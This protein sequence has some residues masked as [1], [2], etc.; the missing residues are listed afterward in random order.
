MKSYKILLAF[1]LLL[2]TQKA[3]AQSISISV[4][5]DEVSVGQPFLVTYTLEGNTEDFEKPEFKGF[6][7]YQS[8]QSTSTTIANG[9]VT[10]KISFNYTLVAESAGT[11]EIDPTKAVINGKEVK[12]PSFTIVVLN[13]SGGARSQN[14]PNAP[15]R[16]EQ[17]YADAASDNLEENILLLAET[18]K[19]EIYLGEQITITYKLLRRADIQSIEVS[20]IPVF[21]GFLSEEMVIPEHQTESIISYK[22]KRYH[23]Y[24]FRKMA[25]F[26]SKSGALVIDPLEARGT[27]LIPEK[28]PFF[29]TTFFS[30]M[31]PKKFEISSNKLTIQVLPLPTQ[32]RPKN[33][34]GAVGQFYA[35]RTITPKHI[36]ENES[37]KMNVTISGWG[38]L[39]ALG[40]PITKSINGADIYEPAITDEA[41]TNG[42]IYGGN[43]TFEYSLV[44]K[45]DGKLIVPEE[46]FIYFDPNK[47]AYI[48]Q[49]LPEITLS[50]QSATAQNEADHGSP[51]SFEH[52]LKNSMAQHDSGISF[53]L[54]IAV[55]SG[56]PFLALIGVLAWRKKKIDNSKVPEEEFIWQNL[57]Q[58]S[59][60][61]QYVLL[62]KNLR[63]NLA[64]YFN[65]KNGLDK[66]ILEKIED[67]SLKNQVAFILL[68]C[69]RA[70]FS[71]MAT[72]S[73]SQLKDLAKDTF[74]KITHSALT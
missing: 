26:A 39:K 30:S 61:E 42:E 56:L 22:G 9:K 53:P 13:N 54:A 4:S 64:I 27:V 15:A 16:S 24:A 51:V 29:G 33:F 43:R 65:L 63:K 48:S 40:S 12:S 19:K 46:E 6:K 32:N 11:F 35:G 14:Q 62:A 37:A 70:V 58:H 47:A 36:Y 20:K 5:E 66:D 60:K 50:V 21:N 55:V 59:E 18:D 25:L 2:L 44:P 45:K 28:D 73:V 10:R 23:S 52:T 49:T 67:S 17:Q 69:D 74:S 7:I 1:F 8:G 72:A 71:P 34:S 41:K 31:I 57:E 38:N 3:R 68:S